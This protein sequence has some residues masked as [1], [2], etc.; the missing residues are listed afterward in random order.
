MME[1]EAMVVVFWKLLQLALETFGELC[2][3]EELF[4]CEIYV[5]C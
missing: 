5:H 3:V 4:V 2:C 1:R